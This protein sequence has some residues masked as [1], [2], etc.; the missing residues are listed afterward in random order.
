MGSRIEIIARGL[1]TSGPYVLL[2]RSAAAGY[3]YLPGGHV[4]FGEPA[5]EALARELREE[6][7][8]ESKVGAL[9]LVTE[10]RFNDGRKDRHELNLVFRAEL[11]APRRSGRGN[12]ATARRLAGGDGGEG[13]EG[14][15]FHVEHPHAH[16]L[17]IDPSR[18]DPPHT[19]PGH[20]DHPPPAVQSQ[21]PK[22]VFDW[23]RLREVLDADVRP[24]S[25][26]AW[27]STL[28]PGETPP[29]SWQS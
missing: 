3:R 29:L 6:C 19:N 15:V 14:G 28:R 25:I 12:G 26:R 27:L 7:G 21:E 5:A 11:A 20:P 24:A 17:H 1:I 2:C 13:R 23:V 16:P 9:V 18:I 8:R 4:E 10:E 22:L